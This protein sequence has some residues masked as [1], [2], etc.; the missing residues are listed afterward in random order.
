MELR[1]I[2]PIF[3]V[4]L[5][6]GCIQ[7]SRE[8][9]SEKGQGYYIAS[10]EP[11]TKTLLD[12]V[13]VKWEKND[14]ISVFEPSMG[15]TKHA[16][17]RLQS[18]AGT[19]QG[20]FA[21][22][23]NVGEM[24][25]REKTL[26]FYP[27]A[28]NNTFSADGTL[29]GHLAA[30]TQAMVIPMVGE[31]TDPEHIRFFNACGVVKVRLSGTARITRLVLQGNA[32]EPLA[33]DLSVR[34]EGNEV[35]AGISGNALDK[36]TRE[37]GSVQLTE[38][39]PAEFCFIIPP[40]DFKKGFSVTVYDDEGGSMDLSVKQRVEVPRNRLQPMEAVAYAP[41]H[42]FPGLDAV[43]DSTVRQY[44]LDHFDANRDGRISYTEAQSVTS[45]TLD[46]LP[47]ETLEGLQVF[48][49]LQVLSCR[50]RYEFTPSSTT[51][52]ADG[53]VVVNDHI[54]QSESLL[55]NVDMSF[56]PQVQELNLEGNALEGIRM[57]GADH[58]RL[59]NLNYNCLKALDLTG[60]PLLQL[61][62]VDNN[63]LETLDVSGAPLLE[64]LFI[65]DNKVKV[66]DITG[67]P[68]LKN[69]YAV[70][71]R[72][73]SLDLKQNK[74]MEC[75][76]IG[77]N[78]IDRLILPE[79]SRMQRLFCQYND[80]VEL[81]VAPAVNLRELYCGNNEFPFLDLSHNTRLTEVEAYTDPEYDSEYA[82]LVDNPKLKCVALP[83]G[84]SSVHVNEGVRLV[85][86][87]VFE[88]ESEEVFCSPEGGQVSVLLYNSETP[89]QWFFPDGAT[90]L[91]KEGISPVLFTIQVS[92][93]QT[94]VRR[95]GEITALDKDGSKAV[96]RIVQSPVLA[97]DLDWDNVK[98]HHRS[99]LMR[100]TA[101]W[102][103]NC[104]RLAE[105]MYAAV[106][107][108]PDK[109]VS[110]NMHAWLS[111]LFFREEP[112]WETRF[113]VNGIPYGVFDARRRFNTREDI[114]EG[115]KET[116]ANYPTSCGLAYSSWFSGDQVFLDL[117][118]FAREAGRYRVMAFVVEN[119]II[120]HQDGAE[121]PETY[122]HRYVARRA[123][124]E[125]FGEA[126]TVD[127]PRSVRQFQFATTLDPSWN[128]DEMDIVVYVERTY[129]DKPIFE[130][131]NRDTYYVDNAV[132][133][134]AGETLLL[135]VE[136]A[137]S[138][139]GTEDVR[140]GGEIILK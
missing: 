14:E 54:V 1:R 100:F 8:I 73:T 107:S 60:A 112:A 124:T 33:G 90:L 79:G 23:A 134:K 101:T 35:K 122:E 111:D 127:A 70:M 88:W 36:L 119:H 64:E 40:T 45:M 24:D 123:F 94:G 10:I 78:V 136:D 25:A 62:Y 106:D 2:I 129:D 115:V 55:R 138:G 76:D 118:V 91:S 93:N 11:A 34:L 12:G 98:F 20:T 133:W 132:V 80:I 41:Q 113:G 87:P 57:G 56:L 67:N 103:T 121:Y 77:S 3:L 31:A 47:V 30:T 108:I 65:I 29:T 81:Y 44:C 130:F 109:L 4:L 61:L 16:R 19:K 110:I 97:E 59:L 42:A 27:F 137:T 104:P 83:K 82:M 96:A 116:E 75:L 17:Y 50:G 21:H 48:P 9:P 39:Q 140:T 43:K 5:L 85:N 66:L 102:C 139:G 58:L 37:V 84:L 7:E 120:G 105:E 46:Y 92:P 6:T 125:G 13:E 15:K 69:L 74:Q 38:S 89:V 52:W 117:S 72:I 63:N 126:F 99:L 53:R 51:Y 131:G 68:L 128:R 18:G 26:A 114:I 135:N 28:E 32:G 95:E 22:Q 86:G 49:N 71:N